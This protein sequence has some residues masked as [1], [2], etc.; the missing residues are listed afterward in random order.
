MTNE[1][2]ET[3]GKYRRP[4]ERDETDT[5]DETETEGEYNPSG[6]VP[7]HPADPQYGEGETD[8]D[9]TETDESA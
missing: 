8:T 6:G 4:T 9:D 7:S 1:P 5:G 3:S 2:N